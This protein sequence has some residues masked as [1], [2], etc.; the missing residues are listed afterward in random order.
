MT[1]KIICFVQPKNN[2]GA[3][4]INEN[5]VV[6]IWPFIP[7]LVQVAPGGIPDGRNIS[8]GPTAD[9]D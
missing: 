8:T 4:V 1:Q 9:L 5:A 6:T 2:E 7:W 3:R